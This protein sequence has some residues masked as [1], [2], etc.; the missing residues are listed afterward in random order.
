MKKIT[1]YSGIGGQ[2]VLEGVMMRNRDRYA[3]AVRKTNGEIAVDVNEYHAMARGKVFRE[4][5][6]L[7]GIFVFVDSLVLGLKS[8]NLS[9]AWFDEE[10]TEQSAS[11][12]KD[13]TGKSTG[14]D[15]VSVLVTILSFAI[16]ISAF[17]L[18]PYFLASLFRRVITSDGLIA[19]IEG[20]MRIVV[21]VAYILLISLMKDIRRLF[22]Y[23]GAEHKCI[24]CIEEG[25]P[26]TLENA[27]A[28]SRLHRRCGSS[29]LLFV[30]LVS[31]ILFFFIRSDKL[32]VRL[33][34]RVV[35]IP[36]IAGIS[37][38]LI[39]LAGHTDNFLIRA[40]SAPGLWLQRLTTKEPDDSMIEVGIAS[41]EAVFDWKR[42]LSDAFGVSL[43]EE[44]VEESVEEPVEESV[45]EPAEE[46]AEESAESGE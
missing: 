24:N 8:I 3:V 4:I 33:L 46:P 1:K 28:A 31:V 43:A 21:F 27:R 18:L 6:F 41:V 35:L 5:P 26:L 36:V 30:M 44:P 32:A 9:A 25:R 38:E 22:A 14:D 12:K 45:E 11:K 2:A 13:A 29:F 39:Y 16:A 17:M 10:E 23:H 34:L 7:R 20:L 37:Y 42:Y 15:A 19:V 40:L